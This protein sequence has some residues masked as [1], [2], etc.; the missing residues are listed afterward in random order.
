MGDVKSIGMN[1]AEVMA[2]LTEVFQEPSGR[3]TAETPRDAIAMWDSLGVLT[4]M[5]ELDEKFDL[6]VSD[7]DMRALTKAG[8]VVSLL[9]RHGKLNA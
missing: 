8:D 3:I 7:Q 4:L 5:A 1:E 6:V 2:W 9:R